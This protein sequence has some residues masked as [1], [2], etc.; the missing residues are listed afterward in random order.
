MP[1]QQ[2]VL[3][4]A[5]YYDP[6]SLAPEESASALWTTSILF[7]NSTRDNSHATLLPGPLDDEA[8]W[9]FTYDRVFETFRAVRIDDLRNGT[10][11]FTGPTAEQGSIF[12]LLP[13]TLPAASSSGDFVAAGFRGCIWLYGIPEDL[14][15]A[16][17]VS[18]TTNNRES[19]PSTP[20]SLPTRR[21]S[22]PSLRSITRPRDPGMARTPQWQLLGDRLRNTFVE[23]RRITTLEGVRALNWVHRSSTSFHGERLVVV[24]PGVGGQPPISEDDGM[25]P[26]DGGRLS[27]LDFDNTTSDGKRRFVTIEVGLNEPE[28]LEEEHRDLDTEVALVRRRTVAQRRESRYSVA[29]GSTAIGHSELPPPM[30]VQDTN[31]PFGLPALASTRSS[32]LASPTD[33]AETASIDEDHEVFDDPY[34]HTNPRSG[35]TLRRAATAAAVNRRLHPR[36]VAQEHIVYRRADGREEHP[37]ESDADNWEPP[38]PPYQKEPVPPLP[39]HIQRSILADHARSL[40]RASTQRVPNLDFPGLDSPPIPPL[41]RT[42]SSFV[43]TSDSRRESRFPFNRSASDSTVVTATSPVEETLSRPVTSPASRDGFDDLYDVSPVGTPQPTPRPTPR[44]A[45]TTHQIP[46]RPVGSSTNTETGSDFIPRLAMRATLQQPVSPIPQPMNETLNRRLLDW[47]NTQTE[48]DADQASQVTRESEPSPVTPPREV[49]TVQEPVPLPSSERPVVE[50]PPSPSTPRKARPHTV[51]AQTNF[52]LPRSETVPILPTAVKRDI[53]EIPAPIWRHATVPVIPKVPENLPSP[54]AMPS[55]DQLARLN[56]RS[57]RPAGLSDPS[58]RM[59]GAS[60]H[61]RMVSGQSTGTSGSRPVPHSPASYDQYLRSPPP[62]AAVGAHGSR[63]TSG[64]DLPQQ[65]NNLPPPRRVSLASQR[66][67]SVSSNLRPPVHRLETINSV[68]SAGESSPF[69]S[70]QRGAAGVSR[71]PSRAERSAAKN[72][73]DAKKKG[74][75][76]SMRNGRQKAVDAASSAEWTDVSRDTSREERKSG[77]KCSVM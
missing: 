65:A 13:S 29:R 35:T 40:Q 37:H 9:T 49:Q 16:P 52:S 8:K 69:L 72:I 38:P 19:E 3:T 70:P 33:A 62:R 15:A 48:T 61:S 66:H 55:P 17:I 51:Y 21:N 30:P 20:S 75:R 64:M 54:V 57:G 36:S 45:A 53:P 10:T 47:E 41:Q 39:E 22:A 71:Q 31:I 44:A 28:T 34:S 4:T 26:V 32:D 25:N 12:R 58:R 11:Y 18:N 27:I 74:W 67:S 77:R 50:D 63:P 73:K 68:T 24:A 60:I 76:A 43:P 59:S 56:N 7:P 5:P 23:G 2:V 1:D 6:G 42:R 14:E 46:R